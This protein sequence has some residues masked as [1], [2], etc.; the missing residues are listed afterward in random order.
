[1]R[2]LLAQ[3][4]DRDLYLRSMHQQFANPNPD[5]WWQILVGVLL[6]GG[7]VGLVLLF[8]FWQRRKKCAGATAPL[9]L[10]RHVLLHLGLPA[11]DVWRMWRLAKALHVA[12]PA[13]LLISPAL[14]DRA[15]AGYCAGHGWL[16]SRSRYKPAFAAIRKR[17]FE[18]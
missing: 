16:G 8:G 12:H 1:M 9:G 15:V 10:Y 11:G 7:V 14:F 5:L 4:I 2:T 3:R 6:V 13:A 18:A 17:L